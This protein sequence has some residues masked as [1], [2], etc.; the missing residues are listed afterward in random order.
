MA[1]VEPY[2]QGQLTFVDIGGGEYGADTQGLDYEYTFT[3]LSQTQTQTQS[4]QLTQPDTQPPKCEFY[5]NKV[6][7]SGQ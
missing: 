3:P 1:S 5:C 4:S 6:K 2:S 7:T